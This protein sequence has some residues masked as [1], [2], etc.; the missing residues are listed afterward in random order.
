MRCLDEL[1]TRQINT[2]QS[3]FLVLAVEESETARELEI[4]GRFGPELRLSAIY[5]R[6]GRIHRTKAGSL[7]ARQSKGVEELL[8]AVVI[9]EDR[10]IKGGSPLPELQLGADLVGIEL[11]RLGEGEL[12]RRIEGLSVEGCSAVPPG[13]A[14]VEQRLIVWLPVDAHL[15]TGVV[16]VVLARRIDAARRTKEARIL[17]VG[18]PCN[19]R[20]RLRPKRRAG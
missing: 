12:C 2:V 20:N 3:Q 1:V 4:F 18:N 8:V 16:V 13:E 19:V 9:M 10:E 11:L 14:C 7:A 5:S 15:T 6:L 17:C